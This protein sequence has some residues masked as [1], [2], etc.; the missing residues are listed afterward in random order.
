MAS[1]KS[2][3]SIPNP[4]YV[5]PATSHLLAR[6]AP[7]SMVSS[8]APGLSFRPSHSPNL[9]SNSMCLQQALACPRQHCGLRIRKQCFHA[10]RNTSCSP[11]SGRDVA[12]ERKHDLHRGVLR[13][14][15]GLCIWFKSSLKISRR[16]C[17]TS[18]LLSDAQSCRISN[19]LAYLEWYHGDHNPVCTISPEATHTNI[20]HRCISGQTLPSYILVLPPPRHLS[21]VILTNMIFSASYGVP[22]TYLGSFA[23]TSLQCNPSNS[24]LMLV[25]ANV[26]S[27]F[28]SLWIGPLSDGERSRILGGRRLS[29]SAVSTLS[30][31]GAALPIFLLWG[32]TPSTR[33]SCRRLPHCAVRSDMA[34]LCWRI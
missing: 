22:Q 31:L 20:E 4:P 13:S 11:S 9:G 17:R 5:F 30:A 32:M 27:I 25:S 1:F 6:S 7:A 34:V 14:A 10:Y 26:P 23:A 12:V 29:I 21:M 24:A 8:T 2:T 28:A 3:I 18:R 16:C 15:K 33:L 19:H